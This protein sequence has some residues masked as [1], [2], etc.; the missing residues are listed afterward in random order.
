MKTQVSPLSSWILSCRQSQDQRNQRSQ[1]RTP[2][3]KMS[4][5]KYGSLTKEAQTLS[6]KPY[7]EFY[8]LYKCVVQKHGPRLRP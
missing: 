1:N 3:N 4:A 5:D 7:H 2:T 6:A 8:R